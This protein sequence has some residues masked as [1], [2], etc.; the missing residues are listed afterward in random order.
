V[1]NAP[2]EIETETATST[3]SRS[4]RPILADDTRPEARPEDFLPFFQIPV[5]Q[6][7]D[8]NVIVPGARAPGA[9][10]PMPYSSA[11]YRQTPR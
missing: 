10:S 6:P 8:V 1:A 11:T 9:L 4:P 2:L 7:D 3:P 5:T